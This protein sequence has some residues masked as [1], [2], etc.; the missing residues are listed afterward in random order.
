MLN[1]GG[2]LMLNP[3]VNPPNSMLM[4]ELDFKW[5][6]LFIY[7]Y[8]QLTSKTPLLSNTKTITKLYKDFKVKTFM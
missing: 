7:N 3:M 6:S 8:L 4:T 1:L 5:F 2:G